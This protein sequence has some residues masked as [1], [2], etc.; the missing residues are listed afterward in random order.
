MQRIGFDA[1]RLFNNNT[2]LGNY[3]RTL[4][5]SLQ[6]YY[7]ENEYVLFTP[8]V[9]SNAHTEYFNSGDFEIKTPGKVPGWLWRTSLMKNDINKSDID[10]Y[11]GLSHELPLGIHKTNTCSVVTIHDIIYML[12]PED[13]PWID[14]KIYD[15]KFRYSCEYSDRIIAI[16][17]STKVDIMMHYGVPEEKISV[18]Y[19]SCNEAFKKGV[20]E[21]V[22]ES[23]V[24]KYNLPEQF[25]LYVGTINERKN[26]LTAVKAIQLLG[27]ILKIP[28]LVVGNGKEYK[29]KVVEY[30]KKHKLEKK[31]IF[32]PYIQNEDLPALYHRARIFVFPSRYEGFGIPIIEA[33][34]SRTPVITT[35]MSSLP[36]AAGPG[37]YYIDPDDPSTISNGI[38]KLLTSPEYYKELMNNGYNHVQ[39]FN[40]KESARLLVG[41]YE[42]TAK[43][44]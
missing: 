9:V 25:L 39:S 34:Y 33:L 31:I 1:K 14:R 29:Q 15:Y 16:S 22:I 10:I 36:E 40:N 3:S 28:L 21:E 5:R 30:I 20:T 23:T 12:H 17:Q 43:G 2:G 24:K 4:V 7:P 35:R 41:L 6:E 37:A 13:F 42:R 27:D 8:K 38:V 18:I 32:A 44:K 11:H 19:Q 26:L